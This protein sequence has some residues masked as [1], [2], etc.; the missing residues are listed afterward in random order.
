MH[1]ACRYAL[2]ETVLFLIQNGASW[3]CND[4][5]QSPQ[6]YLA[7]AQN[8]E[9]S[10]RIWE[11]LSKN[12]SS[13]FSNEF[14]ILCNETPLLLAIENGHGKLAAKWVSSKLEFQHKRLNSSEFNDYLILVIKKAID[15]NAFEIFSH[16]AF[17]S[18]CDITATILDDQ[19]VLSYAISLQRREFVKFYLENFQNLSDACIQEGFINALRLGDLELIELFVNRGC[20]ISQKFSDG[21]TSLHLAAAHGKAEAV[22]YLLNKNVEINATDENGM[23]ALAHATLWGHKEVIYLLLERGALLNVSK[24]YF[25]NPLFICFIQR[26]TELIASF[27]KHIERENHLTR[28]NFISHFLLLMPF[29]HK[30]HSKGLYQIRL[31]DW[32]RFYGGDEVQ[33]TYE[34]ICHCAV[35][36]LIET[37]NPAQPRFDIVLNT[38]AGIRQGLAVH[39]NQ[40]ILNLRFHFGKPRELGNVEKTPIVERYAHYGPQLWDL[41]V[42]DTP[43]LQNFEKTKD[44]IR[45][46]IVGYIEGKKIPLTSFFFDRMK[47]EGRMETYR[48]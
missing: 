37:L 13:L 5:D 34:R 23:S 8:E 45:G 20:A 25:T 28:E 35:L 42:N 7:C 26:N 39:L 36:G 41:D 15:N 24:S 33:E 46:Q 40:G 43:F 27:L 29:L 48:C 19:S 6:H 3:T 10:L 18:Y 44:S 12:Y 17:L 31:K 4:C 47:N 2:P 32:S 14:Y 22:I 38:L 11:D 9:D 16:P 1:L 21:K 30:D